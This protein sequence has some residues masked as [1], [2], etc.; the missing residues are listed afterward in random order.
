VSYLFSGCIPWTPKYKDVAAKI[1]KLLSTKA[2][3]PIPTNIT[4][5]NALNIIKMATNVDPKKRASMAQI[6]EIVQKI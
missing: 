4:N 5:N 1:Q 3:F 6:N 2:E